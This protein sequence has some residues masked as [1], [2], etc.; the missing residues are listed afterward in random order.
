MASFASD[1]FKKA[2]E[3]VSAVTTRQTTLEKNLSDATSNTNWGCSTTILMEVSRCTY[4]F[5]DYQ[6]V[7]KHVWD[8]LSERP[9]SKWRRVYKSLTLL[10]FLCKN[11]SERC[12]DEVREYMHKIKNLSEFRVIEEG[13]DK[14]AGVREK[15]KY[16]CELVNDSQMLRNERDKARQN[17]D[18]FVGIGSAGERTG[19]G[20]SYNTSLPGDSLTV[21]GGTNELNR[22][23]YDP[24]VPKHDKK[25]KEKKDPPVKDKKKGSDNDSEEPPKPKREKDKKKKSTKSAVVDSSLLD[26]DMENTHTHTHTRTHT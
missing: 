17:R 18:K 16:I 11:G 2:A 24:Y 21:T 25:E 23:P 7:M 26:L 15:A 14:G 9:V 5:Q 1:L 19:A 10:E 6:T 3:K 22:S 13:R 8:S 4:D 20:W 12:V